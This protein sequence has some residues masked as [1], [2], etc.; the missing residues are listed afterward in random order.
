VA[1]IRF[2][3]LGNPTVIV[4]AVVYGLLLRLAAG[5]GLFGMLLWI[6][7]MLSLW[8]YGY[9]VLRHVARGW[10]HFPPPG[11]ETM[12]PFGEFAVIFHSLLFSLLL[13]LLATTPFVTGLL[14]WVL[15]VGV[16]AIFPASAAVMAMTTN[17]AASLSPKSVASIVRDLGPDYFKLLGVSLVLGALMTV[18]SQLAEVSWVLG[19][20][21]EMLAVWT[22]LALFLATGAAL[23][24]HRADFDLL[25]GL[26]DADERNER[27][28]REEWQKTLDR[29]YASVRSGLPAEAYR[30]VKELLASEGESLE[31]YQWTFNGMLAWDEPA[32]AALLG[33]RFAA[34][35]WE[36]GR[37]VDA[38]EL[39]QRCRQLSLQFA[40]PSERAAELAAY[41]RSIG[42]H[43]IADDLT[44]SPT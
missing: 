40:L 26:D 9:S 3:A 18:A 39:V 44:V 12:N 25:E 33:E 28:R 15:L 31:I 19:V 4:V 17:I 29:A 13:L 2:S 21:G 41:A 1:A 27:Q 7:V 8:R 14:R 42:R 11:I 36:A 16:L 24:A 22:V 30:T 23:R 32:H 43:R 6:L 5:A 10:N 38:L 35:L 37:K 20:V 34:K